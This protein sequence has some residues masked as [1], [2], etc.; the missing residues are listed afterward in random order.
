MATAVRSKNAVLMRVV[1]GVLI[2]LGLA[3]LSVFSVMAFGRVSGLEICAETLERRTF[4]FYEV[5]V[6]RWQVRPTYHNDVSGPVEKH[7]ASQNLVKTPAKKT[8]HVVSISRGAAGMRH[9]DAEILIRYL[10]ARNSNHDH[11]W[12]EWT[13]KNSKLAPHVWQGVCD[14]AVASEYTSI[15]DLMEVAQL[16]GDPI[17]AQA[18]IKRLVQKATQ[19]PPTLPA[20]MPE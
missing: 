17:K 8:W 16:A 12:L 10:D 15:P 18:E 11:A 6:I 5:P 20:E 9:G 2:V 3:V 13:K 1:W 14:L 7:L 4:S 19:P